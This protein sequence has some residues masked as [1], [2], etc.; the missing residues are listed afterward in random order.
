MPTNLQSVLRFWATRWPDRLAVKDPQGEIS[1]GELGRRSDEIAAGLAARGLRKGDRVG[2]LMRNRIEF[3]EILHGVLKC[4]GALTLLNIRFT[5]K[6]MVYAVLD[7]GVQWVFTEDKYVEL[8]S[9][10]ERVAHLRIVTTDR[11][12]GCEHLDEMRQDG[13][14]PPAVEIASDDTALVCYTSGTSGAAKG[15]M[16]THNNLIAAG[17]A[18]VIAAG[19]NFDDKVLLSLSL[20]YIGGLTIYLRDA[21]VPGAT[22]VIPRSFNAR[23]LMEVIER[24]RITTWSSVATIT[25]AIANDPQFHNTDFTSLRHT[26]TG[27]QPVSTHLL[28]A[29]QGVGVDIT[30]AYGLTEPGGSHATLL[31][32]EDAERKV[33]FAGRPLL[34][35]GL[36]IVDDQGRDLPTGE[37]GE[38]WL[39]GDTIMKGYLNKP[40]ETARAL[41]GGW[42]H[43]GDMGLVD[44]EGFLKLVDRKKDMLI[45]GGLNV[46]PAELERAL[47]HLRH[48]RVR[49]H[50][51]QGRPLGR[52]AHDRRSR[53]RPPRRHQLERSLPARTGRL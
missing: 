8:L 16:L 26:I 1:W 12:D 3:L 19:M 41:E 5:P 14:A 40:E 52:G 7:A 48:G 15:A 10:A 22:S 17:V 34:G 20:A 49:R 25:E 2:I 42:L 23:E 9:D 13:A 51:R 37:S 29:W 31:F 47:G 32:R 4:G 6:E 46:Y 35:T 18:R 38:I 39:A 45:S 21:L 30:Q 24:E 36:R 53:R 44:D 11:I 50:R 28:R 43:T 27:G 33:G